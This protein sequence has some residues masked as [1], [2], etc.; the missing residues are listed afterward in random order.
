MQQLFKSQREFFNRNVTKE[1]SFRK[2]QLQKL[3]SLLKAHEDQ[4]FKA[5]YSDFKKSEFD[6]FTSELSIL[7]HEIKVAKK[8][9]RNWARKKRIPTDLA[10]FPAKSYILPEPLG[11]CLV[12][13]AWNYP[14]LLSL[15]PVIS[16]IAAGNTVILKPSELPAATSAVMAKL[17]NSNFAP[18][19]LKVVE[20]GV[21]ETTALLELPFDKIFFT[22]STKVGKIVYTAAA[23]QLIP[24]TLELGGK[25][26][27]IIC[28]DAN[29]KMTAKR[30]VWGKFL[31]AG[32]TCIAPDYVAVHKNIEK[33]FLE[34]LKAEIEGE[35]FSIKNHNYVQI[36]N[37][38]N[39]VRLTNLIDP[40][41]VYF[42]GKTDPASRIIEP[43][44]LHHCTFK[45]DIMEEEIFGPLLPVITFEDI[46][47]LISKIKTL[48]KP[49]SAY[50]FTEKS[51]TKRKVLN[52]LSFGGGA[53]NDTVMHITNIKLPFGGVGNSGIGSY[54]GEFGFKAFSH[55]K[56]I[57]DKPTWL[58][59]PLKYYPHSEGSLKWIR[60][61]LKL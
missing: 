28:E 45:D 44:I 1:L 56:S 8:Q 4:L 42:G 46:A 15:N 22:G 31:N 9:L 49:L 34:L 18:E 14:Y 35:Q 3:E 12:I 43:T 39:F 37:D 61:L 52:E 10:N 57:I 21:S 13:G 36:I 59:L 26:P 58:E 7:Y 47:N 23:K 16:A 29:L 2:R 19:V 24:V 33:R 41:K 55:Q 50:V 27:A 25:S 32:Q 53:V 6:T 5:I 51:A 60:R 20:G 40:S 17:I 48:P 30:L 11:V 38:D 54:H